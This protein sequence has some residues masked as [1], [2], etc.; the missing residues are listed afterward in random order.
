VYRVFPLL[1]NPNHNLASRDLAQPELA[2]PLYTGL[3]KDFQTQNPQGETTA[4]HINS[5]YAS[6]SAP[7]API[8]VPDD[9]RLLAGT[10]KAPHGSQDATAEINITKW[11][12]DSGVK[13]HADFDVVR[14]LVADFDRCRYKL[15]DH[16]NRVHDAY[17]PNAKP[18]YIDVDYDSHEIIVDLAGGEVLSSR[19]RRLTRPGEILTMDK[20][21]NLVLHDEIA[22]TAEY[23]A[24]L[25]QQSD[26][27]ALDS[28]N[29]PGGLN[30]DG[31]PRG[32]PPR[33][34]AG[35]VASGPEAGGSSHGGTSHSVTPSPA[36]GKGGDQFGNFDDMQT[37]SSHPASKPPR[38]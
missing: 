23:D 18:E 28:H 37:P 32:L 33:G 21:G 38:S 5:K 27:D 34:H 10:V 9:I 15:P 11:I 7:T 1:T 13:A 6:W 8:A 16:S 20:N 12:E 26:A 17:H 2:A 19:D 24:F 14:G 29:G 30:P 36:P 3:E 35:P 22:D 31:S 25:K 4:L